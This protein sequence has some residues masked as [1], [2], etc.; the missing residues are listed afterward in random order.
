[1]NFFVALH[2]TEKCYTGG[3]S[4][5]KG[6]EKRVGMHV[7]GNEGVCILHEGSM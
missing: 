6:R 3:P 7:Y 2:D 5:V 4:S 1:M